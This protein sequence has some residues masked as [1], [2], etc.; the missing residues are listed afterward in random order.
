MHRW[1]SPLLV[2][3]LSGF[4][5]IAAD[6]EGVFVRFRL[7]QPEG[8]RYYVKL[9]GFVH[10]PNWYLPERTIPEN[11]DKKKEARLAV[12]DFTEWYDLKSYL[13]KS[14]HARQNRAGGIAEFPNV[15]ARFIT[16]PAAKQ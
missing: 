14:F 3:S 15:T 10:V 5:A 16:E 6:D 4:A 8:A 2:W 12:G 7:I 11:A 13:G 1:L 9:G